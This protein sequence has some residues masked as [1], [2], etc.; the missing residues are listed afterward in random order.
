M[1]EEIRN[2]H[3]LALED[4]VDDSYFL[5]RAFRALPYGSVSVCSSVPEAKAYICG[6]GLYAD[7]ANYPWPTG[8]IVDLRLGSQSGA[9]FV[10]WLRATPECR[11]LPVVILATAVTDAEREDLAAMGVDRFMLKPSGG[12]ELKEVVSALATDLCSQTEHLKRQSS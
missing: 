12:S 4:N 5:R 11:Q 2:K 1:S 9:D 6:A 10:R 3:F 8:V 7:R